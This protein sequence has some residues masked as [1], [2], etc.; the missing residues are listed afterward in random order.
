MANAK[1]LVAGVEVAYQ[2]KWGYIW[3]Q[4][5]DKWTAA[6]QESLEKKYYSDSKKYSNYEMAAK[7]GR[8]WIGKKVADCSGLPYRVL[9]NLG[10]SV[11]HG[12]NT[13]WKKYLSHKGKI[14]PGMKLPLG[15]AIFTGTDSDKPHIG[16]L[17]SET[18]VNEAKGTTAGVVHTPL[19][20]RKWKYW[21]LYKGVTYDFIPGEASTPVKDE[22]PDSVTIPVVVEAT[23]STLRKGAKG[24]EVVAMQKLLMEAGEKLP[25]YGADGDFGSETLKALKSY[26]K[27][28]GLV[29]DGIC[30]P[31][32]W[33]KLMENG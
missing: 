10:I 16:T 17:V 26:Q 25:K 33:T 12:S 13:I 21:G 23:F 1:D 32:T 20:N 14:T 19:S 27:K 28:N 6:K 22:I 2:E 4:S 5:G 8:K 11:Y 31:K 15:A 29:V 9:K 3:G 24:D 18:C 30:G 7:Y